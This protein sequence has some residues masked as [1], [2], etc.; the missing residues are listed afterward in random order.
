MK[1][2]TIFEGVDRMSLPKSTGCVCAVTVWFMKRQCL[3]GCSRDENGNEASKELVM[4]RLEN[5]V[6][7]VV[8][9]YEGKNLLL[10]PG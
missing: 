8:K 7:T 4:Q 3:L 9:R 1:T 6:R 5:H 2:N 10:R